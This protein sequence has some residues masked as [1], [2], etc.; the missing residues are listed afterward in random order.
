MAKARTALRAPRGFSLGG[1]GFSRHRILNEGEGLQPLKTSS[2]SDCRTNAPRH[3][4]VRAQHCGAPCP[5]DSG[6][7]P[8]Y[9]QASKN[10]GVTFDFQLSTVDFS[11]PESTPSSPN[12]HA[13]ADGNDTDTSPPHSD[14]ENPSLV[15]RGGKPDSSRP[16][17]ARSR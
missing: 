15:A 11:P 17:T 16:N 5:H 9:P 13:P 2:I 1:G 4:H 3:S 12:P 6:P 8:Q 14:H 10:S 7:Y